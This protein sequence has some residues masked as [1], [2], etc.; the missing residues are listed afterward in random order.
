MMKRF[1]FL[2]LAAAWLALVVG[3]CGPGPQPPPA[4]ASARPPFGSAQPS[5]GTPVTPP[6][7][8]KLVWSD[9][10]D[11]PDGSAVDATRWSFAAGGGGWGNGELEDYTNKLDNA[12]IQGGALAIKA[13]KEEGKPSRY[14]S[15]RLTTRGKGDWLYGRVEVRAKLP[16]GQ[17]IWPAIWMMPTDATYGTWPASGEIDIMEL[18]GHEPAR[19]Y[20]TLHYGN[21]HQQQGQHYD[22][23][24]GTFADDYHTFALEW[25][26]GEMRWYVDGDRYQTLTEWH[27]SS[28]K[29]VYPA[30]FDR[31]FYLILNVAVGGAW[32]GYPDATTIFPQAMLVDY[33]RVYQR[34]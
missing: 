21:P 19:V 11:G 14:T 6:P 34:P 5:L 12:S 1:L 25:E 24:Q 22:L 17:G 23:A 33:V 27:T 9:E 13:K 2:P 29:G 15:A 31:R 10:F 26:P 32:P 28:T 4:T 16:R 20:G 30:P 18:L 3:G 8:W 7:G